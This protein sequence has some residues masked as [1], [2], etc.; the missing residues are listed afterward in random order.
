MNAPNGAIP[1]P[2]GIPTT[3]P[4][5]LELDPEVEEL[6]S[7]RALLLVSPS[8]F[9]PLWH[10]G[11][12]STKSTCLSHAST[13]APDPRDAVVALVRLVAGRGSTGRIALH[14]PSLAGQ[15]RSDSVQCIYPSAH[16]R[17]QSPAA[18]AATPPPR[19]LASTP[20]DSTA[21]STRYS[22]APPATGRAAELRRLSGWRH[23]PERSGRVARRPKGATFATPRRASCA[24]RRAVVGGRRPDYPVQTGEATSAARKHALTP[25]PLSPTSLPRAQVL[26]LL[27]LSFW[28]SYYLKVRR[29]RSIHETIIAMF[30]GTWRC[31]PPLGPSSSAV[32]PS[33][34]APAQRQAH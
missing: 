24:S 31:L 3:S 1:L 14:P 26:L 25:L 20:P 15:T 10:L 33:P 30:S 28:V 9:I 34:A 22:G 21:R 23:R 18:L 11:G 16:V 12:T 4:D 19:S 8:S 5:D 17:P 13:R 7:S 27:I 32:Q 2:T 29:I 6:W